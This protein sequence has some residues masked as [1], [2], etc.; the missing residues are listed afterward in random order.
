LDGAPLRISWP[1]GSIALW[2]SEQ[3]AE[4]RHLLWLCGKYKELSREPGK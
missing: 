3:L 2:C 1:F 4:C